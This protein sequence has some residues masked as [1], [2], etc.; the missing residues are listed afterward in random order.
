MSRFFQMISYLLDF[1]WV[2][3][4]YF[5]GKVLRDK[6]YRPRHGIFALSFSVSNKRF[7]MLERWWGLKDSYPEDIK[8]WERKPGREINSAASVDS[9][10][11]IQKGTLKSWKKRK[12]PAIWND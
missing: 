10:D 2:L 8:E 5:R 12:F 6:D 9:K 7:C 1:L 11:K 3:H 4:A